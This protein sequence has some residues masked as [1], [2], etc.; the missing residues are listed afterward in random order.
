MN[1]DRILSLR[2]A[3]Q[4]ALQ[5][6][7]LPGTRFIF[8]DLQAD[9]HYADLYVIT[10]RELSLVERQSY[11]EGIYE[12]TSHTNYYEIHYINMDFI[13]D[14]RP[15]NDVRQPGILVFARYEGIGGTA[16]DMDQTYFNT[17]S[18]HH[19]QLRI[20]A[21]RALLFSILPSTRFIWVEMDQTK[22]ITMSIISDQVLTKQEENIYIDA[23]IRLTAHFSQAQ[24]NIVFI[25]DNGEYYNKAGAWLV[26]ARCEDL[27]ENVTT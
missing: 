16:E 19:A 15:L 23:L 2:L 24:Y 21:Q 18:L 27:Y 8:I 10:D 13:V 17:P 26:Y 11:G 25:V 20:A 14:H 6:Y 22:M 1:D 7:V 3:T 12:V 4:S 5:F 9:A